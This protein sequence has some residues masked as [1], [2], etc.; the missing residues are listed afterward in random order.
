MI[1]EIGTVIEVQ[2]RQSGQFIRI[3]TEVKSTCGSCHAKDNCGTGDE[4][5]EVGQDVKLGIA[6]SMLLRASLLVYM[7]P[8]ITMLIVAT[9]TTLLL[10]NYAIEGE[11]WVILSSL[12]AA[13]LSFLGVKR[14][15]A[16][17]SREQF[18]PH[19][20]AVL[21]SLKTQVDCIDVNIIQP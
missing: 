18:E 21:P 13:F 8:L 6:E 19:L 14:Y 20:L 1:E 11:G 5:V 15:I 10:S 16:A 3:A 7:L 12:L 4:K 17:H 9:V 2:K